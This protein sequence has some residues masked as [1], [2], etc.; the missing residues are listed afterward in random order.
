MGRKP[1]LDI[2]GKTFNNLHV[3]SL[4][5][6]YSSYGKAFYSCTCLIC[7]RKRLVTKSDL[8]RNKVKNC[9]NHHKYNDITG[10]IFGALKVL[11]AVDNP[12]EKADRWGVDGS[13]IWKCKCL[14]CKK[15][16]YVS[17][18]NLKSGAVRSCECA[19]LKHIT[20]LTEYGTNPSLLKR[21]DPPVTNTSG[22]K[23]VSY[24]KDR[25]KWEAYI[26]FRKKRYHLGRYINKKDAIAARKEAEERIFGNFLEWYESTKIM[27]NEND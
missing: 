19:K 27:R 7:G 16:R 20:G 4:T 14:N 25:G 24:C 8:I 9:G 11:E 23:G 5:D 21:K 17:Y 15:I 26:T 10:Q 6:Q 13:K 3:D 18:Y 12:P 1:D 22:C 2:I